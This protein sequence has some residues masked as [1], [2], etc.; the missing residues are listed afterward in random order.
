MA[1]RA[2]LIGEPDLVRSSGAEAAVE[3]IRGDRQ[4]VTAVGGPHPARPRHDGPDTMTPHQSLD[5]TSLNG[6]S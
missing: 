5:A 6:C 3:Q 1:N 2:I 4:V